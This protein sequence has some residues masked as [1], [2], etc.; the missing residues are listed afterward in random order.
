MNRGAKYSQSQVNLAQ[1]I[2]IVLVRIY[3]AVVS[4]IFTALFSPLGFGCRFSPTCSQYALEAIQRHG[5][6]HGIGLSLHRLCRCHP[7]GGGSG[8]DPVPPPRQKPDGPKPE[9]GA[10]KWTCET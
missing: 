4:P 2:L 8:F 7:W 3:R 10:R 6:V 1:V 5:A 9:G